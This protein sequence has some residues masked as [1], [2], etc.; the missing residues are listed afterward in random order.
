MRALIGNTRVEKNISFTLDLGGNPFITSLKYP[1]LARIPTTVVFPE[2]DT[3]VISQYRD[4]FVIQLQV[5]EVSR[6]TGFVSL[7]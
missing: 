3:P 6:L 7:S 1:L 4:I 2:L 5:N